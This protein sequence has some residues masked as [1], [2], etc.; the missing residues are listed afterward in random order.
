MPID[1]II[2]VILT[3]ASTSG[4]LG[5]FWGMYQ[6]RESRI[7]N[8]KEILFDLIEEFDDPSNK[9]QLAK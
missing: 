7:L 4:I 9:M 2:D 3:A 1:T 8:R 5:L 6:Y